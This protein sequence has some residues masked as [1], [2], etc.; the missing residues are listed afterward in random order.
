MWFPPLL[1]IPP[2]FSLFPFLLALLFSSLFCFFLFTF[3]FLYCFSFSVSYFSSSTFSLSIF[4]VLL[5]RP[6]LPMLYKVQYFPIFYSSLSFPSS[7]LP[8]FPLWFL[9]SLRKKSSLLDSYT[10]HTRTLHA[11]FF[12]PLFLSFIYFP[13]FCFL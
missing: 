5:F 4:I 10:L 13:C 3:H 7:F 6:F 2:F 9:L 8:L 11:T 1:L 12:S